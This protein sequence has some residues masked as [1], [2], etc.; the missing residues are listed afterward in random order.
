M[1][2]I[3][4]DVQRMD[5]LISD[6][7]DAS[8]LD[9]ELSRAETG[10]VDLGRMLSTLIDARNETTQQQIHFSHEGDLVI[11]GIESRLGQVFA[12]LLTNA[13]SFSTAVASVRV[14]ANSQDKQVIITF[15]DEGPGIPEGKLDTIF[16]RFYCERPEA[17][18]F[19]KHSGLG[20]SISRQIVQAHGG[21]IAAEN[22]LDDTGHIT[23]AR[24]KVTLPKG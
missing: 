12:N 24:F 1:D 7:S 10:A 8:R 4:D 6:I 9:S 15:D 22:R 3:L 19:G 23:G 14:Q 16:E 20:L 13:L 17:E 18:K 5:R 11:N 21:S 2:I